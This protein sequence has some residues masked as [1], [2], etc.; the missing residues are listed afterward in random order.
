MFEKY[1]PYFNDTVLPIIFAPENLSVS[2]SKIPWFNPPSATN[3][4]ILRD[5]TFL[6]DY[7]CQQRQLRKTI[8]IFIRVIVAGYALIRVPYLITVW[9]AV[10]FQ[11][12]YRRNCKFLMFVSYR[13]YQGIIVKDAWKEAA[14]TKEGMLD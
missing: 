2:Q 1:Y 14:L 4:L 8:Q 6:R 11:K 9:L 3:A 5:T 7:V 13:S 12:R 10:F